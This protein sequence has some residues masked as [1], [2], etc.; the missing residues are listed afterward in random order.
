MVLYKCGKFRELWFT[1]GDELMVE[2]F[3]IPNSGVCR[4]WQTNLSNYY[5]QVDMW[6]NCSDLVKSMTW[7][8]VRLHP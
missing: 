6:K 7:H 8:N 3:G 4:N 2:R 1:N 5:S